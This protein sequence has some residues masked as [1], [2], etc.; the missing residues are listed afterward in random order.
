MEIA[1]DLVRPADVDVVGKIAVGAEY[2]TAAAA[3]GTRV[4]MYDL[5]FG[6]HAGIG[7]PGTDR[8]DT[9]VRYF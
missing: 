3:L 6:M 5:P 7:S 8:F 1:I 9:L 2:P 4:N